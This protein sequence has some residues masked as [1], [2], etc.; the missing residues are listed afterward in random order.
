MCEGPFEKQQE[1]CSDIVFKAVAEADNKFGL[2]SCALSQN[3]KH[4]F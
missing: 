1:R 2:E 4:K 3:C